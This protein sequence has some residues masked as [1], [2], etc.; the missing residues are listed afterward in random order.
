MFFSLYGGFFV[1]LGMFLVFGFGW[2][3]GFYLFVVCF[4]FFFSLDRD[5]STL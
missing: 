5:P 4:L 3:E 1:W 2:F